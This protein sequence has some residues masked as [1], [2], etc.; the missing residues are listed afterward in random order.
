MSGLYTLFTQYCTLQYICICILEKWNQVSQVDEW[1]DEHHSWMNRDHINTTSCSEE[2]HAA[3]TFKFRIV[4][5]LERG[6]ICSANACSCVL[7]P[8]PVQE[9]CSGCGLLSF[10][11]STLVSLRQ[12]IVLWADDIEALCRMRS[13]SQLIKSFDVRFG[14]LWAQVVHML[15]WS[16]YRNFICVITACCNSV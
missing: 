13:L 12:R 2:L 7:S 11:I 8:M 15:I 10:W 3:N 9:I 4:R 6:S 1:W 5:N 16:H 14:E